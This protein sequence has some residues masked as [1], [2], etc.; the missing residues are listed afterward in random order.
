MDNRA[1]LFQI[2][3]A[4]AGED[5]FT[6]NRA[7]TFQPSAAPAA[8]AAAAAAVGSAQTV[9][10]AIGSKGVVTPGSYSTIV[11]GPPGSGKTRAVNAW[12]KCDLENAYRVTF[13]GEK[14]EFKQA[15]I[16]IVFKQTTR[17]YTETTDPVD[18]IDL[19][20]YQE[21]WC[22]GDNRHWTR[23]KAGLPA[24]YGL[25]GTNYYCPLCLHKTG[26]HGDKDTFACKCAVVCH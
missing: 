19:S 8:G 17:S 1:S 11:I 4:A 12:V 3:T 16:T 5:F 22:V 21:V 13:R 20:K 25:I 7:S 26:L 9:G 10:T 23:L 2:S 24:K 18:G 15:I 14:L 6:P